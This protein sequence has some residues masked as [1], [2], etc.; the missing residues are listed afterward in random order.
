MAL[1]NVISGIDKGISSDFTAK[2]IKQALH[3]LKE[4]T[5]QITKDDLPDNI[6]SMFCLPAATQ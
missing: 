1:Q 3:H 4:L 6:F 5:A 2:D